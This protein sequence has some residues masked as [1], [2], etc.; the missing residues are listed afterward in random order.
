MFDV[1]IVGGGVAAFSAALFASRRGLKLL[2]IGKD[3]AGQANF[4]DTIENFPSQEE[5]GGYELVTKI[6]KQATA[7]GSEFLEAEVTKVKFTQGAFV[8]TAYE[9][10]YKAKS[11]ILAFGK[12]PRDLGVVGEQELK[13]HGVTYCANCDAPLYKGKIVAVAGIGDVAADAG[14]LL[15]KYAKKVYIF[16]KTD[17]F[18]AHPALTKALFRKNNVELVPFIQIQQLYGEGHLTGMQLQN[19]KTGQQEDLTVDGLFVE[20]GYVVDSKF[21][22]NI[23]KLDEQQQIIVNP[24][25]STSYPGIFAAGDATNNLYKQAVISAGEG[26]TAA[27]ACYDW[28]MR[29]QGGVG[30]TS[31]WTQIKKLK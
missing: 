31:D 6:R 20:L 16:S 12:T 18:V 28:L 10:Q 23:V 27:L 17:K 4:T 14:I 8:L 26:A 21:V 7:H 5:I 13:G 15:S 1:I 3:I 19:L 24:D 25:Q 22:E 9:K 2:V 11:V 29:Q 30:L